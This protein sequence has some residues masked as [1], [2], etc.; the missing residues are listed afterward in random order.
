MTEYHLPEVNQYQFNIDCFVHHTQKHD[1]KE[2]H[3]TG[4][5]NTFPECHIFRMI[6]L[7]WLSSVLTS[8]GRKPENSSR[9]KP[10]E[11]LN[12]RKEKLLNTRNKHWSYVI[13]FID[14][15]CWTTRMVKRVS[16]Q[17]PESWV[18][19]SHKMVVILDHGYVLAVVQNPL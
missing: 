1:T 11:L 14:S 12:I 10:T 2:S 16:F 9:H 17:I 19:L 3:Y 18:R 4:R 5:C 8:N 6:N 7:A 13:S 15:L